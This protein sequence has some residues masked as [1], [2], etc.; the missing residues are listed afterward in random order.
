MM[1]GGG[2]LLVWSAM[3]GN[4]KQV[5]LSMAEAGGLLAPSDVDGVYIGGDSKLGEWRPFPLVR[6]P[7]NP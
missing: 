1:F 6:D 7:G 2:K 3:A 4:T 5:W